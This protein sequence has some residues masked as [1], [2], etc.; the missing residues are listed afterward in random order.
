MAQ[1]SE[2]WRVNQTQY[3][4]LTFFEGSSWCAEVVVQTHIQH[5]QR[6]EDEQYL[7]HGQIP[8]VMGS[9]YYNESV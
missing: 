1:G 9:M 4:C 6:F 5:I 8:I 3:I 2:L 7:V